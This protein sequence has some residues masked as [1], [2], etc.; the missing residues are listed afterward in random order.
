MAGL[1]SLASAIMNGGSSFLTKKQEHVYIIPIDSQTAYPDYSKG[2]ALQYWPEEISD[3]HSPNYA[4]KNIPGGNIPLYQWSSGGER[5]ITFNAKFSRDTNSEITD[6]NQDKHN[7]DVNS[8][9]KWFRSLMQPKYTQ[10]VQFA[11]PPPLLWLVFPSNSIGK[12]DED[13]L[14]T[15]MTQ[16]DITRKKWFPDGTLRVAEV[17]LAFTE[18]VQAPTGTIFYGRESVFTDK[19]TYNPKKNI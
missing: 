9:V 3:S 16:C 7:I 1:L 13:H 11:E 8:A 6:K 10:G 5:K 2:K 19:Y 17:S 15:I 4:N 14:L 12:G 18:V